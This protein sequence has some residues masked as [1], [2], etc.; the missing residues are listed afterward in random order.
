MTRLSYI[1]GPAFFVAAVAFIIALPIIS[2]AAGP[3][4]GAESVQPESVRV[5]SVYDGDTIKAGGRV[6]RY[7][8]IDTPEKNEPF[9]SEAS[10]RN[11]ELLRGK[12]VKVVVCK[13][14]PQDK[15]GRTLAWVYADGVLVNGE[16]LA[17][18]L[19]RTLIISPC[20]LEKFGLLKRLERKAIRARRGIW[21]KVEKGEGAKR[22]REDRER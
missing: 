22:G 10:Q 7:I 5:Q 1:T 6:I 12:E 8:G 15:Y 20:G 18:G 16:L 11:A 17:E 13:G 4:A 2:A 19:A 9:F 3:A 21:R 14:E